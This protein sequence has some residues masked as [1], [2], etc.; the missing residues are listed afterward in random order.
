MSQPTAR[1]AGQAPRLAYIG[2]GNMGLP[3]ARHLTSYPSDGKVQV[4]NRSKEKYALIPE[5]EGMD[6]I[7]DIFKSHTHGRVVVFTSF[8]SDEVA[9][10]VY[11]MMAKQ[12]RVGNGCQVIFVDQST[13]QPTTSGECFVPC[14][15]VSLYPIARIASTMPEGAFYLAAPVIGQ[16][17]AAAAKQLVSVI[18]GNP[19]AIEYVKPI[20][21]F[22]GRE[23][24]VVGSD[25]SQGKSLVT[26]FS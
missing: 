4:W 20:L 14:R 2:L 8:P 13:L 22:I 11:G 16:P 6:S 24:I 9:E 26:I 10:E 15:T 12:A 19:E 23:T 7:Q 5:A 1:T 18:A 3:I 21:K 17:A 25:V